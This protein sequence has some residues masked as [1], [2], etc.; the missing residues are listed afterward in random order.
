MNNFKN[1]NKMAIMALLVAPTLVGCSSDDPEPD[2]GG[3]GFGSLAPGNTEF[4]KDTGNF[5]AAEWDPGGG[6]GTTK[7]PSHSASNAPGDDDADMVASFNR[8][9][10]M[11]VKI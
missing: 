5:T 10:G 9:G 3:G 7:N 2:N 6:L 8:G 4:G 11:F 1:L